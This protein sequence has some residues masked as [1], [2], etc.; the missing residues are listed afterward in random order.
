MQRYVALHITSSNREILVQTMSPAVL[1]GPAVWFLS[2]LFSIKSIYG[3]GQ[4][5]KI[6]DKHDHNE[7]LDAFITAVVLLS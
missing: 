7:V 4:F 6:K 1:L 2:H 3:R 5:P